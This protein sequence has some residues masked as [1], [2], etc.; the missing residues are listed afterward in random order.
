MSPLREPKTADQGP[1]VR[2]EFW[3][4]VAIVTPTRPNR[5]WLDDELAVGAFYGDLVELIERGGC[6]RLVIDWGALPD[7]TPELW[8]ILRNLRLKIE[9]L[10]G[11]LV[12]CLAPAALRRLR[13]SGRGPSPTTLYHDD[14]RAAIASLIDR[15]S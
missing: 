11:S 13:E 1:Q 7:L 9:S 2:L 6:R 10:D 15:K 8:H 4:E 14:Q 12:V 5:L 3:R